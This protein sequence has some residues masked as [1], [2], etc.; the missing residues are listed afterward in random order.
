MPNYLNSKIYC[1]RSHQTDKIYIGSTT[2]ALSVR[3]AGHRKDY[4]RY[5]NGK[6]GYMTSFELLEYKDAYIE[7]IKNVQCLCKEGLLKHEG[8]HIRNT[9]NCVNKVIAGRTPKEYYQD[10]KDNFKQYREDNKDK[11]K[12]NIK[13][14]KKDNKEQIK[15]HMKQYRQDNKDKI[16]QQKTQKHNCPCGGRYTQTNKTQHIKTKKHQDYLLT[17]E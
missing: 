7:L 4:K 8:E 12:E 2:Q 9:P 16:K 17:P 14:W 11:I 1:I 10:N 15:R 6:Y 3:M 5:K 13:Q